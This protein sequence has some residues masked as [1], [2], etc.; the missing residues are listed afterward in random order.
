MDVE[1]I[2]IAVPGSAG[3]SAAVHVPVRP[4]GVAVVLGHGAGSDM[5]HPF[6]VAFAAALCERGHA[7]MRFNFPYKE[8]GRKAPDPPALLLKTVAAAADAMRARG[9]SRLVLGGRS[10]GGRMASMAVAKGLACDGL[11]FLG[12]PLHPAGKPGQLRDRHLSDV[13]QRM[14]FVQGSRD[15]LCDLALLRPVLDRV[16]PRAS[17]HVVKGGD[18][19]FEVLKSSGRTRSDVLA[20]VVA[21]VDGWLRG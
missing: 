10:M 21:A 6:L 1:P 8:L 7:A 15:A 13:P 11:V 14:L 17:L 3:V 16:G 9:P 4:T 18:H 5:A 12:Y 2:R 19:S 20:E